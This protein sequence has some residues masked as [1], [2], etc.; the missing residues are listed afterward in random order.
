M[1]AI[2]RYPFNMD[3]LDEENEEE[4]SASSH[5]SSVEIDDA[6]MDKLA[7]DNEWLSII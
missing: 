1:A 7:I 4:D 6:F 5:N 2:L 3:Y